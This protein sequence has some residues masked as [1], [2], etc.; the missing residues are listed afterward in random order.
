M[1]QRAAAT[2]R[3]R[4]SSLWQ[5][6]PNRGG[7]RSRAHRPAAARQGPQEQ[8]PVAG[9]AWRKSRRRQKRREVMIMKRKA[10]NDDDDDERFIRQ[11]V[12]LC[13]KRY[14]I[15]FIVLGSSNIMLEL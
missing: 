4:R 14:N 5:K 8:K 2:C 3:F 7:G 6:Q 15:V 13:T 10:E 12:C 11:G 9:R 1:P